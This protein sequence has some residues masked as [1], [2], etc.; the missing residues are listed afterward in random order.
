MN[1]GAIR[2]LLATSRKLSAKPDRDFVAGAPFSNAPDVDD[3][4]KIPIPKEYTKPL[5]SKEDVLAHIRSVHE[6]YPLIT[7][8]WK[9]KAFTVASAR[10]YFNPLSNQ[11][12]YEVN[13]PRVDDRLRSMINKTINLLHDRLEIDFS[14]LKA[15][16]EVYNYVDREVDEIWNYMNVKLSDS[17]IIK[18]KYYIFRDTIGLGKIDPL[19]KD[20]NLEDISCDGSGIPV[21]IFH[22][23]PLYGEMSTNLVFDTKQELDSFV[24]KLAQ[25]CGRTVSVAAPLLDAALPDGS[26][27]QVTYGTDIARKGSNFS[28]RKFFKVPLTIVDLINYETTNPMILAYLWLAI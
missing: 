18:S 20:P 23:N 19:M 4:S 13:E 10:I 25:K 17:D 7:T 3:T 12:V 24:M 6:V 27:I 5:G 28:I 1:I 26:R 9:G 14:R 11:L 22:R 21:F 15:K 8:T 16:E 2:R